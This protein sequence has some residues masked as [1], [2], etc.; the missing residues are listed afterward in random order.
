IIEAT[1]AKLRDGQPVTGWR[2]LAEMLGPQAQVIVRTICTWLFPPQ[3]PTPS[4]PQRAK[5]SLRVL[6]PYI[7]FPTECLPEPVR[8]YVEQAATA[9][10]CDP[11]YIALPALAAVAS[12]IG[13]S[14][15]IQLKRGWTEPS[16]VWSVIVGDSGTLKS[17]AF[18]R[19]VGPLFATQ[20]RLLEE[21][22]RWKAE[23]KKDLAAYKEA[24]K[25]FVDGEG[26]DPGEPPEEPTLRR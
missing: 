16:I 3:S 13:N 6:P 20:R 2:K 4:Q 21:Y 9:L 10:G 18:L 19:A 15:V 25:N 5:P 12:A 24:K 1:A 7:P 14:R 11:A 23:Y 22:K 17:P 26:D 8:A